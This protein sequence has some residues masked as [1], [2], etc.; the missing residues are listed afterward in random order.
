MA[1]GSPSPV[2]HRVSGKQLSTADKS[3]PGK[4]SNVPGPSADKAV[5]CNTV[6]KLFA[7]LSRGPQKKKQA[8]QQLQTHIAK[9]ELGNSL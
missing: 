8:S 5:V 4:H 2:K 6:L 9:G 7:F 3:T 1:K